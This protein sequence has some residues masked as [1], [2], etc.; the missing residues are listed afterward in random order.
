MKCLDYAKDDLFVGKVF[1]IKRPGMR[2]VMPTVKIAAISD[3]GSK[4]KSPKVRRQTVLIL[5]RSL[6]A[7][8]DPAR[9]GQLDFSSLLS[10]L[11]REGATF[12]ESFCK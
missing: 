2:E 4:K 7:C 12:N 5:F 6:Y 3:M 10:A 8:H 9:E 11:S 1:L